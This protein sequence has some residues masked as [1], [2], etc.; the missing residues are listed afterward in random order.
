M[1]GQIYLSFSDCMKKKMRRFRLHLQAV[2]KKQPQEPLPKAAKIIDLFVYS[3]SKEPLAPSLLSFMQ[4]L[5]L[6]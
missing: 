4:S 1:N 2:T 5:L 3:K 6:P